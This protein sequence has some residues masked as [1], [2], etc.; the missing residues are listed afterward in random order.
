MHRGEAFIV[1][2]IFGRIADGQLTYTISKDLN[3]RRIPSPDS[4]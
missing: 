1:A 4:N 2:E 3:A